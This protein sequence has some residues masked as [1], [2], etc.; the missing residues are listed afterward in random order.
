MTNV[1]CGL[2]DCKHNIENVMCSQRNISIVLINGD[3][4]MC[5]GYEPKKKKVRLH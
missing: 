4:I 1:F 2:I 5:S 3:R